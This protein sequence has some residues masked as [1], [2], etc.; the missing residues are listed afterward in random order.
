VTKFIGIIPYISINDVFLTE[1]TSLAWSYTSGVQHFEISIPLPKEDAEQLWK[2]AP[3]GITIKMYDIY[4][5]TRIIKNLSVVDIEK[6]N[7]HKSSVRIA[8]PRFFSQYL[9][10]VGRYNVK[11]IVND[12]EII[13]AGPRVARD[14]WLYPNYVWKF[15]S[16]KNGQAPNWDNQRPPLGEPYTT[17]E[18]ADM[19]MRDIY[20]TELYGGIKKSEHYLQAAPDDLEFVTQPVQSVLQ[21]LLNYAYA[22]VCF[23]TD[24]KLYIYCVEDNYSQDTKLLK[25]QNNYRTEAD[26]ASLEIHRYSK[27]M[28]KEVRVF[29]IKE[30]EIVIDINTDKTQTVQADKMLLYPDTRNV[31]RLPR[32]TEI[33][34]VYYK[35][36][37]YVQMDDLLEHLGLTDEEV[38]SGWRNPN[39]LLSIYCKKNGYNVDTFPVAHPMLYRLISQIKYDYRVLY[40]IN[41]E[42]M[43]KIV[44]LQAVRAAIV[45]F[46]TGTRQPSL[47]WAIYS[48]A[49]KVRIPATEA[50]DKKYDWGFD[51]DNFNGAS[52]ES[53][54]E[55]TDKDINANI[56]VEE[57][58]SDFEVNIENA[59]LGVIRFTPI[60]DAQ[61]EQLEK[62]PSKL[63]NRP[64]QN[65][66]SSGDMWV[67]CKLSE[68]HRLATVLTAIF[69]YPN[70]KD[71]MYYVDVPV[72]DIGLTPGEYPKRYEYR[73]TRMNARFDFKGNIVDEALIGALAKGEAIK[74]LRF[75]KDRIEGELKM[76][77]NFRLEFF[78]YT[79]A[80]TYSYEGGIKTKVSIPQVPPPIELYSLLGKSAKKIFNEIEPDNKIEEQK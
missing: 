72:E 2:V 75:L 11:S 78:G 16:V 69:A 12:Y 66:E 80:I 14:W 44:S 13:A 64:T 53:V 59:K 73:S 76:P 8:D 3:Y 58:V 22:D 25:W 1:G 70:D 20:G 29:F 35:R 71:S 21:Q 7:Y 49:L 38:C 37:T 18:L 57:K 40:Q 47:V 19:I 36:G 77:G 17:L 30:Q 39:T 15:W 67:N 55:A 74:A 28:P 10:W 5:Q 34:G 41:P 32:N 9:R 4:S 54:I 24:N 48:G 46:V 27:Q 43:A 65:I 68:S 61:T 79:R 33:K 60:T 50:K 26:L 52:T 31:T 56:D 63:L 6:D 23:D 62:F 45:D 51:R 42:W